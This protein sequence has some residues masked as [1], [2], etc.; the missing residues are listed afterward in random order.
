MT[1]AIRFLKTGS[2]YMIDKND[3][4]IAHDEQRLVDERCQTIKV[5][6][7]NP[8]YKK[9]IEIEN[10]MIK[11]KSG[12]GIYKFDNKY[13]YI[14]YAPVK[15]TGWSLGIKVEKN[16][17]LKDAI[18][19]KKIIVLVVLISMISLALM[20]IWLSGKLTKGL[21]KVEEYMKKISKGIFTENI[22]E[23]LI[24]SKDE[25]GVICKTLNITQNSVG[26]MI[27]KTKSSALI[28][29]H[30]Y[31]N[32]AALSEELAALTNNITN[33]IEEVASGNIKQ[34]SDLSKVIEKLNNFGDK[35]NYATSQI[36]NINQKSLEVSKS[37]KKSKTDM[38]ELID[39]ISQ[40][41]DKFSIFVSN[42]NSMDSDIK[43]VN[44]ITDL[45]NSIAEQT[46]LLALNAA[47][48]AARA[49][50]SGKGFAVV[51]DEI[52][53]L[54]EQSRESSQNIYNIINNLL[55]NT[56]TIV[57]ETEV[58]NLEILT[59]KSTIEKSID[60]FNNISTS[61]EEITPKINEITL[62]FE[63]INYN[64][65]DILNTIEELSFISEEISASSEEISA[66]SQELNKSSC[67]VAKSAQKLSEETGNMMEQ[68]K[69]FKIRE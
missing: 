30:N 22:D 21:I 9:I 50:E 14:A 28:I 52:R 20:L 6:A 37:S 2:A 67:E 1:K 46:N 16:D 44:E 59:Q 45:I 58:M 29:E 13:K 62:S 48:E 51:A 68:V 47:I 10:K 49:R 26:E 42:I 33:S 55:A 12:V 15:T 11:G 34:N 4:T 54:A 41:N 23:N 36:K 7:N 18:M 19:L 5:N 53:K 61:V 17:I 57:K 56:K 63:D 60:S 38:G 39:S 65:Q 27:G 31:T 32:L 8:S 40:F 69:Q 24:N 66:S 25:I 64:K 35:I 43:T 3:V